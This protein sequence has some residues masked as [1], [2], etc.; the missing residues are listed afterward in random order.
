MNQIQQP[1]L[2]ECQQWEYDKKKR[3]L[4]IGR[5]RAEL[6][7]KQIAEAYEILENI[8]FDYLSDTAFRD[9]ITKAKKGCEQAIGDFLLDDSYWKDRYQIHIRRTPL[10]YDEELK[11]PATPT[12]D[13]GFGSEAK[14]QSD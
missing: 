5:M 7:R 3:E 14:R 10:E 12:D 2:E 8:R 1:T 13:A 4:Q 6:V 9:K 11:N